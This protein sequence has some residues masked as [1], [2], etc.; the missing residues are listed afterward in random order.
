[1]GT[2][3]RER[4]TK[5]TS[6]RKGTKIAAFLAI[7]LGLFVGVGWGSLSSMGIDAVAYV[8]PLGAL[9]TLLASKTAVPR[10]IIAFVIILALVALL[11]RAFCSWICP[12]P[13]VRAFF[14]G[15][16]NDA[17]DGEN[18]RASAA[19]EEALTA[20]EK[21]LVASPCALAGNEDSPHPTTC[22]KEACTACLQP[23]GGKRDTVLFDSRH[24]VLLGA[25]ASAAVFG[26]PVFCLVCPVGLTIATVVAL[27]QAFVDHAPSWSLLAF[28]L[29]L[30]AEVVLFR[31][32]CH[33]LCPLGA[34][35]SLVGR[36]SL[37]KPKIAAQR[38]LRAKGVDCR[39]CV[40]ACPEQLDPH[41]GTLAE[42]T[43]CGKCAEACPAHAISLAPMHGTKASRR[44]AQ[45]Q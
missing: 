3:R 32:W 45:A 29:I 11:G 25:L 16:Q 31:K 18:A 1:M 44:N 34:L 15:K 13:P 12:I 36:K 6:I 26:F 10:L 4:A 43:K 39:A 21:N 14:H 17:S 30:L 35:M 42:C 40:N 38:C 8:C 33:K 41:V 5:L 27:W 19:P 24:G 37:F 28:P 2:S 23:V 7:V 22:N 20:K 9:E